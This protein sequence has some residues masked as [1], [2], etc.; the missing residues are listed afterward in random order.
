MHSSL[1]GFHDTTIPLLT[2]SP[3]YVLFVLLMIALGGVVGLHYRAETALLDRTYENFGFAIGVHTINSSAAWL[4]TPV[5]VAWISSGTG[6]DQR[7]QSLL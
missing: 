3:F 7:S 6:G 1:Y 2:V 4:V 5:V